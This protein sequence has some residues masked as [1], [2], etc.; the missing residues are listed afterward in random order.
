MLV[1]MFDVLRIKYEK[2]ETAYEIMEFLQAMFGQPS[3]QLH[4]DTFK[5]AMNAKMKPRTSVREHVLKMINWLNEAEIHGTMIDERTQVSMI[6]ESLS[7]TFL[8]FKSN[9]V[10][11]KLSYNMTQ[12]LNKLQT[13]KCC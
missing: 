1:G 4:H 2:M 9:H 6:L 5:A 10:I 3:N 8:Q 12:L 11:N 7:P 13:F